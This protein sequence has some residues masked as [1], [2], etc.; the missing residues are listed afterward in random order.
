MCGNERVQILFDALRLRSSYFLRPFVVVVESCI[1]YMRHAHT[2][3]LKRFA[4]AIAVNVAV[5]VCVCAG[6]FV[7]A[8]VN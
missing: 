8:L 1:D 2:L 5:C 7:C 6:V 3:E 4:A